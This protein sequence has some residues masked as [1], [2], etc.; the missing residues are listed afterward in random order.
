MRKI[1][2]HSQNRDFGALLRGL[3]ADIEAHFVV[4]TSRIELLRVCKLSLYDLILTDDLRMFMNGSDAVSRIRRG[5]SLPQI[6]V[7]SYNI[8]EETVTALL[9]EGVNQF[10]TLPTAAERLYDKVSTQHHELA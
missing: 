5:G 1:V 10:I 8:S 4:T 3:L 7:L 2:I 9:E 6:F